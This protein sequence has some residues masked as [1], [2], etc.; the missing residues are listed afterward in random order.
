[1]S[2]NGEIYSAGKNFTLPPALTE[3]TNSTSVYITCWFIA[4]RS[5]FLANSAI[6]QPNK[7]VI[8]RCTKGKLFSCM[9]C[10]YTCTRNIGLKQNTFWQILG[11]SLS[12]AL[13]VI[14]PAQSNSSELSFCLTFICQQCHCSQHFTSNHLG[15]KKVQFKEH[16]PSFG[17]NPKERQ[18]TRFVGHVY[19]LKSSL[20]F[21]LLASWWK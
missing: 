4:I 2:E 5:P 16:S 8:S 18:N 20:K 11:E 21:K 13:N 9:Q 15:N 14:F 10:T 12:N 3:W 7:L 1:M 19:N 17:Q 6:S